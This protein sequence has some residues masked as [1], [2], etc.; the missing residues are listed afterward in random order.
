[1]KKY[2]LIGLILFV[3]GCALWQ[4]H[5]RKESDSM[6]T[7]IE[8]ITLDN[9]LKVILKPDHRSRVTAVQMWVNVGGADES[10]DEAGI[11]HVVEHMLFKG[12]EKRGVGEIARE[13]ESVG[14][15]INAYTSDDETVFH[16]VVPSSHTDLGLDIISDMIQHSKFDPHEF[17]KEKEV[18]L[19][20]IR[21]GKDDPRRTVYQEL[22][23][24]IYPHHP[25]GRPVIGYPETVEKFTRDQVYAYYK[26]WYVPNNMILVVVGDFDPDRV[27][28]EIEDLY[29]D[30]K[31]HPVNHERPQEQYEDRLKVEVIR[32]DVQK[33]YLTIGYLT[34]PLKDRSTVP[35]DLF[36]DFLAGENNRILNR[37]LKEEKRL[38]YFLNSYNYTPK[39]RGSFVITTYLEPSRI[40]ATTGEIARIISQFREE[41]IPP[42]MLDLLKNETERDF[43]FAKET[44]QGQARDLGSFQL[45]AGDYR[46]EKTYLSEIREATPEDV[47]EAVK[48]YLK[49]SRARIL[50]M[51]P[52]NSS[53]DPEELKKEIIETWK[54]SKFSLPSYTIETL[55]NNLEEIKFDHRMTLLFQHRDSLPTVAVSAVIP[56]GVAEDPPGKAGLNYILTRMWKKRT[57]NLP[58]QQLSNALDRIGGSISITPNRDTIVVTFTFLAHNKE[59]A[60]RIFKEI[61][62]EPNFTQDD[63]EEARS[64]AIAILQSLDNS[65]WRYTLGKFLSLYY[66]NFPYGHLLEGKIEDL[67]KITLDDVKSLYEKLISHKP[68]IT[69]VVGDVRQKDV[70]EGLGDIPAMLPP[71]N[72]EPD[73]TS[74]SVVTGKNYVERKDKNQ[75]HILVGFPGTTIDSDDR[76]ILEI[77]ENILSG[78]GNR[79]FVDLRDRKSLAYVVSAANVSPMRKGFFLIYLATAPDKTDYAIESMKEEIEKIVKDGFTP[80]E[81]EDAKRFM[82]GSL[83]VA[84][85]SNSSFAN[86]YAVNLYYHND[87]LFYLHKRE[88]I[89]KVSL[90]QVNAI[91][92]KYLDLKKADWVIIGKGVPSDVK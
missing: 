87:P 23:K 38:V 84:L 2:L 89:E 21:R 30:F 47:L 57:R 67:R 36:A 20:E 85:Q 76:V 80:K 46:Y 24:L 14:G 51:L 68:L 58:P 11:S 31:P 63:L 73:E 5:L 75:T 19:E 90:D 65:M 74:P 33:A 8:M 92:R 83:D 72:Y 62:L 13:I 48:N 12:T 42:D 78:M 37:V 49:G 25:Y 3:G 60:F 18:I 66:G 4:K 77:V 64:D 15:D 22:M 16:L 56:G 17:A 9:G 39:D 34:T 86:T 55:D 91:A 1:M 41:K 44:M 82:I 28:G 88:L 69:S 70:I 59:E 79:L 10:D 6:G 52:E 81:L 26:K 54:D 27:K 45:L 29:K 35:L 61:L 50:V 32:G 7:G 43:I 53:V 71:G 40:T